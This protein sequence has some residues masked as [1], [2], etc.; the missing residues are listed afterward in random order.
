LQG[1][2]KGANL[3]GKSPAGFERSIQEVRMKAL[4]AGPWK[5]LFTAIKMS[6]RQM[7]RVRLPSKTTLH[8][9]M[10]HV[11]DVIACLKCGSWKCVVWRDGIHAVLCCTLRH[12]L[13]PPCITW[14]PNVSYPVVSYHTIRQNKIRR[15]TIR[16][17]TIGYV[18][19]RCNNE[20]NDALTRQPI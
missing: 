14:Y 20:Q 6:R 12:P 2:K 11:V 1:L 18:T 15:D 19:M 16:F 17:D 10:H 7:C 4:D 9:D 5:M 8:E 13:A 3:L